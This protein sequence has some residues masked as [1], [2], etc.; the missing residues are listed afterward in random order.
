[1]LVVFPLLDLFR[2]PTSRTSALDEIETVV[3]AGKEVT[4][5]E[6]PISAQGFSG[7]GYIEIDPQTGAGGYIIEGGRGGPC[8]VSATVPFSLWRLSRL[9]SR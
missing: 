4:I 3:A 7:T 9:V 8:L 1:M 6:S 5:H 2:A